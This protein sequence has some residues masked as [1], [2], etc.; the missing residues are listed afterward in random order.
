MR[1]QANNAFPTRIAPTLSVRHWLHH[2][3][4]EHLIA[5][6]PDL[7]SKIAWDGPWVHS[8]TSSQLESDLANWGCDAST[9]KMI[10]KD[11]ARLRKG[12]QVTVA[13]SRT[14]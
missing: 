13:V 11:I 3:H 10:V 9:A 2:W 14:F 6:S 8:S 7:K 1:C 12:R 4:E 5:F